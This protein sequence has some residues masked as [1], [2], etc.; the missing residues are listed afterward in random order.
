[1]VLQ[2][3]FHLRISHYASSNLLVC[4]LI[5]GTSHSLSISSLPQLK[6]LTA[7]SLFFSTI[8]FVPFI[9]LLVYHFK[10]P[11]S[12]YHSRSPSY[13]YDCSFLAFYPPQFVLTY[14]CIWLQKKLC[15]DYFV[16]EI[17]LEPHTKHT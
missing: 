7:S 10:S 4:L 16:Q 14:L 15:V 8:T 12:I 11:S 17:Q 13:A 5:W 1:M 3:E 6:S 2:N 9:C